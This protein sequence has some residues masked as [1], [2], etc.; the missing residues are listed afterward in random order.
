MIVIFSSIVPP[1]YHKR[2]LGNLAIT[3]DSPDKIHNFL[4]SVDERAFHRR[5]YFGSMWETSGT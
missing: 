2:V 3:F 1:I 4:Q 5:A